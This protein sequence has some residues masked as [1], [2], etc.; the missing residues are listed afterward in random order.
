MECLHKHIEDAISMESKILI[1]MDK[2][3]VQL[4][5]ERLV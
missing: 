5:I 1:I 2:N 4:K 3:I